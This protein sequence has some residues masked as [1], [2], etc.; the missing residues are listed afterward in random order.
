MTDEYQ[1]PSVDIKKSGIDINNVH[2]PAEWI[3]RGGVR[4][5]SSDMFHRVQITV[6]A[7][8]IFIGPEVNVGEVL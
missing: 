7:N 4:V 6:F 3:E 2:I 5:S 8:D 1:M